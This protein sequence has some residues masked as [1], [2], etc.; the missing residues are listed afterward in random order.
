MPTQARFFDR[1]EDGKVRCRL[2]PH[3]CLI[4]PERTGICQVRRNQGGELTLP[5]Y[6]RISSIGLDPVEKKP[7]YH[8]Y[9]GRQVLSVGFVGCSFRCPFC[10]NWQIS[11]H[12]DIPART[13]RP[14]ELVELAVKE[15]SFGIAYTYSEPLIHLEYVLE[16]ARLARRRGIRNILVSNGY[17]NPE[18]AAELLEVLDAANID[19]KAFRPQF[20]REEIGGKLEEVR[21]FLRQAAGKIA[22]EVTTLV[23]P[24]RNDGVEEIE[25]AARFLAGLDPGIPYHLS[26]YYP[27]YRYRLPPTPTETLEAL[28]EAA[29]RH[30]KFVYI[31]NVHHQEINTHC[32]SCGHLLV[33]RQGYAV[34]VEGIEDGRCRSCG[35]RVPIEGA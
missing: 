5:F 13:L 12:T 18:P 4:A 31:G 1:R 28:A 19:L 22:L 34:R 21:R 29:R 10:Q 32:P 6:A 17:V 24:T 25:E 33:R 16:T 15:G 30:L 11:Q 7:L 3:R 2:C 23:I 20:Y 8:Y 26:G 35:L 27:S 14:E 9:P